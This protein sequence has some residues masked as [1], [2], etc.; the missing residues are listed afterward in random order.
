MSIKRIRKAFRGFYNI[1]LI[2]YIGSGSKGCK[3]CYD[4]RATHLKGHKC[5]KALEFL[6][7][8]GTL[9]LY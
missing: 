7:L 1:N 6:P 3:K 4:L 2:I 5:E 8:K 9:F